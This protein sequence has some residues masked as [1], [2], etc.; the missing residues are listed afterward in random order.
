MWYNRD[1][2]FFNENWIGIGQKTV[3]PYW[4]HSWWTFRKG[5][6]F[7]YIFLV[8]L[9]MPPSAEPDFELLVLMNWHFVP[10]VDAPHHDLKS[11][12]FMNWIAY[13]LNAP[14]RNSWRSQFMK[15][16]LNYSFSAQVRYAPLVL[17]TVFAWRQTTEEQS[18]A[19]VLV[20]KLPDTNCLDYRA[21]A[22]ECGG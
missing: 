21:A 16:W 7:S 14:W 6:L 9:I 8:F 11:Y 20:S 10:W 5:Q 3:V 12:D 19:F 13:I 18:A 15:L 2:T 17:R 4:T 22:H 1:N